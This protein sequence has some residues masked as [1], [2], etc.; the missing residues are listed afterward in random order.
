MGPKQFTL[1]LF[2][3]IKSNLYKD[4]LLLTKTLQKMF[5][6]CMPNKNKFLVEKPK[7]AFF[8][9]TL[10]YIHNETSLFFSNSCIFDL[11]NV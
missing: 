11:K 6:W 10:M 4:F 5:L 1:G 9:S 3:K 2:R 8:I 7:V